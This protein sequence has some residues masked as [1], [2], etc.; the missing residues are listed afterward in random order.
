MVPMCFYKIKWC[1]KLSSTIHWC[2]RMF[3]DGII[4]YKKHTME[5]QGCKERCQKAP[6]CVTLSLGTPPASPWDYSLSSQIKDGL[7]GCQISPPPEQIC[8]SLLSPSF[9]CLLPFSTCLHELSKH[10]SGMSREP[11]PSAAGMDLQNLILVLVSL[12]MNQ[13]DKAY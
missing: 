9:H 7:M 6:S 8:L 2:I 1:R 4:C 5:R 3:L 10:T 12:L 13:E 11:H